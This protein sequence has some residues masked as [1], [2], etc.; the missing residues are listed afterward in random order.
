MYKVDISNK[1]SS[2]NHILI[3]SSGQRSNLRYYLG[4]EL[5][6]IFNISRTSPNY[7]IWSS[8]CQHNDETFNDLNN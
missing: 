6:T 3:T 8:A 7:I 4:S 1:L 2:L 5:I